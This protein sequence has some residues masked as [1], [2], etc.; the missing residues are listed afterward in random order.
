MRSVAFVISHNL[1]NNRKTEI[2]VHITTSMS[3]LEVTDSKRK[4]IFLNIVVICTATSMMSTALAT[5]LPSISAALDI[6]DSLTQWL[7]SGYML[8]MGIMMPASAFFVKRFPTKMLY[9]STVLVFVLGMLIDL[10][11][12]DFATL[13]LGRILQA[14]ANGILMSMAQ[15]VLL[16]I[17]VKERHGTVLGWYGLSMSAAPIIAPT[18]AGVMINAFGWRGAFYI[19]LIIAVISLAITLVSMVDIVDVSKIPFDTLSFVTCA[20]MFGGLTLGISGLTTY[21]IASAVTYVPLLVGVLGTAAFVHR[22]LHIERP[23]LELRLFRTRQFSL[24][25]VCGMLYYVVVMGYSLLM[26]VCYQKCFGCD[27]A[28]A[29]FF[30][31]PSAL[32]CAVMSPIA[33]RLYDSHGIRKP[34]IVNMLFCLLA[35]VGVV[36]TSVDM[37]VLILVL[38]GSVIG[39][40][41]CMVMPM[42]TWGVNSV[43]AR[44]RPDATALIN[45]LRTVAG[46]L[47]MSVTMGIVTMV[48]GDRVPTNVATM[49]GMHMAFALMAAISVALIVLTLFARSANDPVKKKA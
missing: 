26:P 6:S 22:Q 2:V 17:Y 41:G 10:F 32:F 12:N 33:G 20:L 43:E 49:D 29:G 3:L 8:V 34:M 23:F 39:I 47:G 31:L 19:P 1:R 28:T 35:C 16:T 11:A 48:A 18:I 36:L 45:S 42:T 9:T 30:I 13:M 44:H 25:V 5:A 4:V 14:A 46:A 38:L 27:P 37:S 15:V 7:T 21:G 40:S 24:S